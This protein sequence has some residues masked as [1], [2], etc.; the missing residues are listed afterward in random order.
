M[1]VLRD[2]KFG[3][4]DDIIMFLTKYSNLLPSH[5]STK[6]TWSDTLAGSLEEFGKTCREMHKII[7]YIIGIIQ[8]ETH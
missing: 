6:Y 8:V 2:Q 7:T 4:M 3:F 1:F 5:N